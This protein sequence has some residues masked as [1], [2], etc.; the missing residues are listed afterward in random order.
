MEKENKDK[1]TRGP[2]KA[3]A[4]TRGR[5]EPTHH[6]LH[7]EEKFAWLGRVA[8]R[9]LG[10]RRVARDWFVVLRVRGKERQLTRASLR[11][12]LR[13]ADPNKASAE[14]Q[15]DRSAGTRATANLRHTHGKDR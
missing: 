2:G 4:G 7:L 6:A 9:I 13:R 5:E 3:T 11:Q 14:A 12:D 10:W 8:T 1:T 15:P